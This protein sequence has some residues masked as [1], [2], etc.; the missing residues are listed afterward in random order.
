M[1]LSSLSFQTEGRRLGVLVVINC[2]IEVE[3]GSGLAK[4][5]ST[6]LHRTS[7]A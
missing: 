1:Q 2:C 3:D 5:T 7:H 4:A 6:F